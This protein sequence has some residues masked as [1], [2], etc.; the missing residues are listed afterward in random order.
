MVSDGQTGELMPVALAFLS[1]AALSYLVYKS[2]G[3]SGDAEKRLDPA[4]LG[5]SSIATDTAAT[6][7]PGAPPSPPPPPPTSKLS[8]SSAVEGGSTPSL[9]SAM[10][11]SGGDSTSSRKGR[12]TLTF[13]AESFSNDGDLSDIHSF[14]EEDMPSPRF[15]QLVQTSPSHAS[16]YTALARQLSVVGRDRKLTDV[17]SLI[18]APTVLRLTKLLF[19]ELDTAVL[20]KKIMDECRKPLDADRCSIFLVCHDKK[21]LWSTVAHGMEM[22]TEIRLPLDK[23]LAG[24]VASSGNMVNLKDAYLD[25]RFDPST[26][27]STGYCTKSI[28]STPM[29]DNEGR[30]TGVFQVI[31]KGGQNSNL[32]FNEQDIEL[33]KVVLISRHY[34]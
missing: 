23:G 17:S 4:S 27:K 25:D 15:P 28:L 32:A 14:N 5:D 1:G 34:F 19:D 21:E 31:N 8:I 30:V 12:R 33:A 29:K 18:I 22:G 11:R 26:D 13:S 20:L 2:N 9:S 7:T 3:A 16:Q 10:R 6:A 24:Y